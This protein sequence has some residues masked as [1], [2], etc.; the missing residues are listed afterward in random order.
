[1]KIINIRSFFV[2]FLLRLV[3]FFFFFARSTFGK[4]RNPIPPIGKLL[5]KLASPQQY[6]ITFLFLVPFFQHYYFTEADDEHFWPV[7]PHDDGLV[8]IETLSASEQPTWEKDHSI[9]CAYL[10]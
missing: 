10:V 3:E 6:I 5:S 2:A 8:M 7:K 1:M 9:L 4:S